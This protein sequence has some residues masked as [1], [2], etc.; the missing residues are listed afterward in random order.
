M[1]GFNRRAD[2]RAPCAFLTGGDEVAAGIISEA[3]SYGWELPKQ[4]AVIGFDNQMITE[5]VQP[6]ISTVY[7]PIDKIGEKA[8]TILLDKINSKNYRV[9]ESHEF[10]LEL[11][12]RKSTLSQIPHIVKT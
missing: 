1:A 4:L 7:Q 11:V 6:T 5:L 3:T 2:R 12:V 10:S 8:V 9:R